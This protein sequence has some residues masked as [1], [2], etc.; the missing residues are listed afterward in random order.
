MHQLIHEVLN[1]AILFIVFY[2]VH[3]QFQ[4]WSL[5]LLLESI[6]ELLGNRVNSVVVH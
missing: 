2:S 5:H 3:E 6:C 1:R 4:C